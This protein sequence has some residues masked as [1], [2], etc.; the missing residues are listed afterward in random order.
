[1]TLASPTEPRPLES[2][3]YDSVSQMIR[4]Y[5]EDTKFS[6]ADFSAAHPFLSSTEDTGTP[7]EMTKRSFIHF[8]IKG[9]KMKIER[10]SN[11]SKSPVNIEGAKDVAIR[12]LISKADGAQNYAMRLF[13]LKPGGFTPL[14]TH[15]HEHEVFIIDGEGIFVYEGKEHKFGAEYVI[16]V[17]GN[18]EHQFK[19]TRDSVLR[20]LCVIPASAS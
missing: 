4:L 2:G 20:F 16:F 3:N 10:S 18:K 7:I 19:N 11:I 1:M 12:L 15:P 13:E 17:P 14:H 5:N 8:H 9:L 6:K